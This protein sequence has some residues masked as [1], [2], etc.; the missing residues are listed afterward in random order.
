MQHSRYRA[1]FGVSLVSL[2]LASAAVQ[3]AE[4]PIRFTEESAQRGVADVA[5]NSTGPA[6]ADFDGD[7]HVDIYVPVEDLADGL[8]DRLFHNDG[9]GNF[10]D[11]SVERGIDNP[12]SL[13]RGSSWGDF[14]RDGDLDLVVATMPS[15]SAREPVKPSTL[16][17]NLLKETGEARFVDVTRDAGLMRAGNEVDAKL[18]GVGDT[19]AG[20]AWGDFDGDGYL[21]LFFKN[22]DGEVENTLFRNDGD[23]TFTDVTEKSGVAVQ[24]KSPE[25]NAQGAPSWTDVDL[26][27]KLDLIITNEG[28]SKFVLRNKGDGTFEDI[29]RNRKPPSAFPF[30]NPG[31][32]E[33]ACIGDIDHDG[34]M[35]VFLPTADQANRLFLSK[36]KDDGALS[37]ED[38]T[39]KSGVGDLGGARGCVMAD[40]DN[41]GWVDIVVNNGGPSN[42]LINDVI[43]GFSP[44]VQFYIAWEKALPVL[45]RN[46]GDRTFTNVT[47]A[48]GLDVPGIGSGV[49]AA[50]V[51]GNGFADL[52]L[53]NRTYYAQRNR[54]SE[55]GQNRLFINGG[56]ANNWFKLHLR[57]T[58]SNPQGYGAIVK[59]VA[60]DLVQYHELT[61]AHGYNSASDQVVTF[62][63]GARTK[64]DEI[65]IRWPSGTVQKL[66]RVKLKQTTQVVEPKA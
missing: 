30:T 38:I 43:K 54:V 31:N 6:F 65:E 28:T 47:V 57:G 14:D 32:A 23:G 8:H 49:G 17:K 44:F 1:A 39:L 35:D 7:G 46:N 5:V 59:V 40:F 18:G 66:N 60:G 36:L 9:K 11:V 15:S 12:R 37:Y 3:A 22:A 53:A 4:A 50:D 56:N 19:G 58:H 2:V 55:P 20:V 29:T 33:G 27:G 51:D 41:D 34:D 45:Y 63:L 62:G 26:D 64:V 48:S 52:F 61:S 25:S 21:D 13:S 42:V 24:E 16:F 10:K